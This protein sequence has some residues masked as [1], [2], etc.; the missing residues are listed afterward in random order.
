MR[1]IAGVVTV[2]LLAACDLIA[3]PGEER[4]RG[5]IGYPDHVQITVPDTVRSGHTF[6]LSVRTTGPNGCWRQDGTEVSTNVLVAIVTPYDIR[7][8]RGRMCPQMPREF[9]HTAELIFAQPGIGLVTV[10]GRDGTETRSV[11]V[12]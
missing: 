11:V 12:E 8:D 1:G 5:A 9:S 4:V 3:E 7:A 10:R 2:V 6:T